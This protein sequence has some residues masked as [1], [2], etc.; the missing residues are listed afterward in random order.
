M[1]YVDSLSVSIFMSV[2]YYYILIFINCLI[3]MRHLV[4]TAIMKV[5]EVTQAFYT[6]V[7]KLH[8]LPESFISNCGTQF[9]S[10]V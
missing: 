4:L 2:I 7:W 1:N 5:E 3:K 10:E 9:I 6:Y 8:E